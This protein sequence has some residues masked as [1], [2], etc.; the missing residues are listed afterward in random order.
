M[1]VLAERVEKKYSLQRWKRASR[2]RLPQMTGTGLRG[3]NGLQRDERLSAVVERIA[4]GANC[5]REFTELSGDE[6]DFVS[7]RLPFDR[8][9]FC[10]EWIEQ[11][12]PGP[13][14]TAPDYDCFGVEHVDVAGDGTGQR[15]D[16]AGPDLARKRIA[17][18]RGVDQGM[19][20]GK[21]AAGAFL[22]V[23]VADEIFDAAGNSRD[24]FRRVH[25]QAV[26]AQVPGA[27][28]MPLE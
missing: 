13:G 10:F 25:I 15:P 24:I 21:V 2:V 9:Q 26:M 19:G 18:D 20:G 4:G 28:D 12:A 23:P 22:D 27:P 3:R 17:A 5:A 8:A 1:H 14:D 6:A 7:G 11:S 16:G